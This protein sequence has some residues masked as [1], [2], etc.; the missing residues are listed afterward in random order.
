MSRLCRPSTIMSHFKAAANDF[1]DFVNACPTPYH[2]VHDVRARLVKNGFKELKEKAS[3]NIEPNGR[4]FVTRN[5]S[6]IVAFTVGGKWKPGNPM[7][8]VGAHTDSP[9]FRVKPVSKRSPSGNFLQIGVECYGG[10]IWHS[11]F[12]RDLS[13]AGRVFVKDPTTGKS[14]IRLVKV[15]KPILKIPTLA[16]HLDRSVMEKFEFNKEQHLTPVLGLLE[17]NLNK[18]KEEEPVESESDATPHQALEQCHDPALLGLLASELD[19]TPEQI[20]NFELY[21]FDTQKSCIGGL[22]DEFIFS[23]RL[24]NQV[25]SYCATEALIKSL[26]TVEK[27]ESIRVIGLFDHEEVGSLSYQG[28]D[29]NFLPA[30]LSRLA[31]APGQNDGSD[32]SINYQSLASS[33]LLSAD[34]AHA[35]HPNYPTSYESAH[36]PDMNRGPVIKINGNQRYTTDGVGMVLIQKIAEKANLPMQKFVVKNDSSCGSTIGPMLASKLGLRSIDI[37]NPQL[38][39]HSVRETGG[40]KDIYYLEKLFIEFFNNFVETDKQIVYDE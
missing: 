39:M 9:T 40:S 35:F 18:K 27:D 37:G 20:D 10:G 13:V 12:D 34:Q 15:D 31:G 30:V 2:V 19:V 17:K 3:W 5:E 38:S 33:F 4:Y 22:N 29:S 25:S 11:W 6:S 8:I 36:R 28:A 24:D 32:V 23:P 21:L 7:A 1:I 26:D 16:I 14:Q